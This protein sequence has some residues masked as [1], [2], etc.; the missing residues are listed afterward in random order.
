MQCGCFE[1]FLLLAV[2]WDLLDRGGHVATQLLISTLC[3]WLT[4]SNSM[5]SGVTSR[6]Q[7]TPCSLTLNHSMCWCAIL[8]ITCHGL[9]CAQWWLLNACSLVWLCRIVISC[10][11]VC[12][13]FLN[14]Q[15]FIPNLNCQ[16][17]KKS[18]FSP[19]LT[20]NHADNSCISKGFVVSMVASGRLIQGWWS[21]S[22]C[23]CQVF[24]F[25]PHTGCFPIRG[26]G[27]CHAAAQWENRA[28]VPPHRR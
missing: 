7:A 11:F 19:C 6:G 20:V 5:H 17:K 24:I 23:H 25:I 9:D 27:T 22:E 8:I 21:S 26:C 3:A 2:S 1:V 4:S 12:L 13:V 16:K 18:V 15:W 10:L 14:P 28:F